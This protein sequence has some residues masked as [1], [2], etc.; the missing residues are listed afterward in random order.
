M[1]AP[2]PTLM[3]ALITPFAATGDLDLDAHRRNVTFLVAAGLAG[4]VVGGS[5]GEG[6]Y[7]E[8]GERGLLLRT[9]RD[10]APDATLVGGINAETVRLAL[11]QIE[12]AAEAGA[13]AALVITPTTLVRDRD[14]AVE[15]FYT[16]VADAATLPV[17]LYTV[18]RVTGYEL[19]LDSV[20]RLSA[21]RSIVGMKDSGG[22]AQRAERLKGNTRPPFHIY[23]GASRA[24]ADGVAAGARGAITASANYCWAL[25]G[26]LIDA[27]A[28]GRGAASLQA[29]LDA[30]TAEIEP[31]GIPGTKTA[32][33]MVGL[34]P[35]RPRRPLRP[36]H[37]SQHRTIAAALESAGL[38][39]SSRV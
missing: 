11:A 24:V 29:T 16:D 12:E 17:L 36:L 2:L 22:E 7:L 27:A 6:P 13:D 21:H 10:A 38:E 25:L 5:T 34:D 8:P 15:A 39:T 9:A 37:P 19:P 28:S 35:G 31:F 26:E 3:P 1:N 4:F 20:V 14:M 32:A 33:G 18:P 30:L 23:I